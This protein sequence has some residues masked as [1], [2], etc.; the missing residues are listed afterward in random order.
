MTGT[1]ARLRAMWTGQR[2]AE[3]VGAGGTAEVAV[4]APPERPT[5]TAASGT[6]QRGRVRPAVVLL[7]AS[8]GLFMAFVD[9]TVVG[10]AFPNM[11]SSFQGATLSELS[12]VLNAYNITFAALMILAGR[13]ADL[14]GRRLVYVAGIVIFTLASALAAVAPSVGVL[15]AA[16]GIQGVGA[17][18]IVPASLALVL[19]GFPPGK[20]ALAVTAWSATAVLAAGIGP[21]IGGAL[22]EAYNWRLVF[23]V[24]LPIG[25]AVWWLS[26]HYLVQSRAPGRRTGPDLPGALLVALSVGALT[27]AIVQGP[28]WGWTSGWVA[29]AAA[30]A[31]VAAATLVR[32]ARRRPETVVD[33]ELLR[34]PRFTVTSALTVVGAAGFFALGLANVLFLMQVWHYSALKAGLATTP[35][36][37]LAAATAGLAAR[38]V[39]RVDPRRLVV[40]GGVLLAAGPL[41]LLARAGPDPDF[42]GT[43]LPAAALIAVGVGFVFPLVSDAAVA[44]APRGRYAGASAVNGAIRQ[45]GAAIGIAI[46]A[47]LF[48]STAATASV[49]AFHRGWVFAA[50]C[51]ALVAIGALALPPYR[52]P[53]LGDEDELARRRAALPSTA[54][55]LRRPSPP[56]PQRSIWAG[57]E[58]DDAL[59]A[60]V[61]IFAG[62]PAADRHALAQKCRTVRLPYGQWLFRQG[63]APDAM[64]IVRS[65]RLEVIREHEREEPERLLELGRG[66]VVGELALLSSAGRSASVRS[67]R[68]AVLLRVDREAFE[69]ML[70]ASNEFAI[71]I[72]RVLASQLQH[73][74]YLETQPIPAATTLAI[75]HWLPGRTGSKLESELVAELRKFRDLVELDERSV[76]AHVPG[77]DVAAALAQVLDRVEGQHELVIL[78]GVP[79]VHEDPWLGCA[80]PQ[81][82]RALLVIDTESLPFREQAP[83]ELLRGCDVIL[84]GP[85][86]RP[87]VRELLDDLRPRSTHSVRGREDVARLARRLAGQAVG[88]VLSGGG[89]RAFAHIGVI[90]ELLAAGIVIDRVGGASMGAF[91]GALLAQG[92]DADEID[93][94]CYQEWVRRNPLGDYRVP[95]TSLIRGGR[96]RT[97]LERNL[98]GLI[99][100]LP[101]SFYCVSTDIISAQLVVHQR[102][103]LGTAVGASIS[104]PGVGPPVRIG[105]GLLVDGGVLDNLPISTM[106]A[107]NEGLIIASDVTEPEQRVL[108]PGEPPP[109]IG[110]I[111]TISRCMLLGT[112]DTRLEGR[113]H[114]A[115]YIEPD[116][117]SVDRLE[118]HMLDAMREAG[119]RATLKALEETPGLALT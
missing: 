89:A 61:A 90:E 114:A 116:G 49:S 48:G 117:E 11:V 18:A 54:R 32:R 86:D 113:R 69:P 57:W 46:L 42:L 13:F 22:V 78:T 14:Y 10:I 60:E 115:L 34:T 67:C 1:W 36:P 91:I 107:E 94:V 95:R 12:W 76:Q 55:P 15:I 59:L 93:A 43:Y 16:R 81:A 74:R 100:D 73:S 63:D 99:E 51:F 77:A 30:L 21:S 24:N 31:V 20:R 92:L 58:D 38:L 25:V 83:A 101:R 40:F 8:L 4:S 64:Y 111:D 118:F 19:H 50:G 9:D 102:G 80:V 110:L 75:V 62:L 41:F 26:R 2:R 68:D 53:E 37:F 52:P 79:A 109:D 7:V 5:V 104:L 56:S 105:G 23:L 96:V 28:D 103:E 72:A 66:S 71:S 35:A 39:P 82:D 112:K 88:L 3:L 44:G 119:R 47:A 29:A 33:V 85:A 70:R 65:G 6:V 98:P 27:L 97:M 45:I 108:P 87:G 106:A 84:L 17:A